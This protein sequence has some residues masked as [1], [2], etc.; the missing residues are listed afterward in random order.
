MGGTDGESV[1]KIWKVALLQFAAPALICSGQA[2][3]INPLIKTK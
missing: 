2:K 3:I 1:Q